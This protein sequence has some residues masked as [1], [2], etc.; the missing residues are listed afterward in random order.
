MSIS[1]RVYL[2]GHTGLVGSAILR[3]LD[4]CAIPVITRTR[5]ELDLTDQRAVCTFFDTTPIDYVIIAAARVGGIMANSTHP[6]DFIRDNLMIALNLIDA[7]HRHDVQRL[8]FLGSSCIYPKLAEQPIREESLLTGALEQTN[9]PYAVAKIAGIKLCQALN[10]QFGRQYLSLM[11]TN[12]Y[13]PGDNFDPVGSHV[14]PGLIRRFCEAQ[15][16]GAPEV[17]VWGTG[18][19]RRELL[20]V[21]DL[22][23]A[24][25]H[26][27]ECHDSVV[28]LTGIDILNVGTG[29]DLP[30]ADLAAMIATASG[31]SG[32]ITFDQTKPDGTP[33]KMLDVSRIHA[34]GWSAQESLH[35]GIRASV[36]WFLQHVMKVTR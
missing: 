14:V 32:Q 15:A 30:I 17:V 12:L 36:F 23:R 7:A 24:C 1:G 18:K 5:E 25:V 20:Y 11:P 21:D 10:R 34:L 3:E 16:A 13:G 6:A 33:R 29:R 2:A 35:D 26:I 31:Y 19:P 22:A 28:P 9:E 8:L 4:R 27:M